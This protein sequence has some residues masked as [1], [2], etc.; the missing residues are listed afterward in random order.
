MREGANERAGGP[1][2]GP[3][4]WRAAEARR[5]QSRDGRGLIGAGRPMAGEHRCYGRSSSAGSPHYSAASGGPSLTRKRGHLITTLGSRHFSVVGTP[6]IVSSYGF[7]ARGCGAC[8]RTN[9]RSAAGRLWPATLEDHV[10]DLHRAK[11]VRKFIVSL[12]DV[13]PASRRG[14]ARLASASEGLERSAREEERG[15]RQ[16]SGEGKSDG[17]IRVKLRLA[18]EGRRAPLSPVIVLAREHV[19]SRLRRSGRPWCRDRAGR[20][21]PPQLRLRAHLEDTWDTPGGILGGKWAREASKE[22][23][24]PRDDRSRG[25]VWAPPIS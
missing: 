5:S 23:R 15:T 6:L 11:G 24:T 2:L 7:S 3:R 10:R 9:E 21:S 12:L 19:L 22:L 13:V 16:S 18:L 20:F 8:A 1:G 14:S 25:Q 4:R 17:A